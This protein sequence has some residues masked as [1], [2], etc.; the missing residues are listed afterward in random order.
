V[1]I[2]ENNNK[3]QLKKEIR[4]RIKIWLELN[5]DVVFGSGRMAL[6]QA[7]EETGSIKQA[8]EKIGMSY[9]AAWGKIKATEDRLGKKLVERHAGGRNS[10]T[11]L[12][13]KGKELLEIY[14][15]FQE[16][17][18]DSIKRSFTRFFE[19]V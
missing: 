5:G 8:A 14:I 10:G 12:T 4:P 15:K 2:L 9:R 11:E 16:D 6:F 13:P 3:N 19:E 17:T 18:A 1:R 7:I